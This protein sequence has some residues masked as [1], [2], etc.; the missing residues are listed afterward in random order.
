MNDGGESP[1]WVVHSNALGWDEICRAYGFKVPQSNLP[2][3]NIFS[4]ISHHNR[5]CHHLQ[6]KRNNLK[7]RACVFV[8]KDDCIIELE[9]R[10]CLIL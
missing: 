5:R 7:V 9:Q 10:E 2:G 8:F 4:S 3:Q 1:S 6:K